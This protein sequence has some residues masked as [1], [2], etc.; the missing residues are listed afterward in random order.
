MPAHIG[1]CGCRSVPLGARHSVRHTAAADHQDR[2]PRRRAEAT[3][4]H[5]L[6]VQQSR[7]ADL[8]FL[9]RAPAAAGCLARGAAC[10]AEPLLTSTPS[11]L[12]LDLRHPAAAT[13]RLVF[14]SPLTPL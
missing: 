9:D 7:L 6:P 8:Q 14:Q 3:S 12:S 2:L 4:P 1:C 10:P 5:L 11:A 13:S